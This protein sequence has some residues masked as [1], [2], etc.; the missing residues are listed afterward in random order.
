MVFNPCFLS[1][2]RFAFINRI[3][4]ISNDDNEQSK[5]GDN[6]KEEVADTTSVRYATSNTQA[7]NTILP[8]QHQR[9]HH[10]HHR[11]CMTSCIYYA[12][13]QSKR[14]IILKEKAGG[15]NKYILHYN[16]CTA[17]L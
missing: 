15:D 4:R 16:N 5:D 9:Y 6:D 11:Y 12:P 2:N 7:L 14:A 1:S 8:I 17:F 13:S 3:N 10:H